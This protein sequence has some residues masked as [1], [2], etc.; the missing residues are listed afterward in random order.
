MPATASDELTIIAGCGYLGKIIAGQLRKSGRAVLGIT[1][2]EAS[3]GALL[4]GGIDARRCDL[5]DPA[6]CRAMAAEREPLL[7]ARRIRVIHCAASGRGGGP[8]QYRAVYLEGSRNLRSAFP[9][10]PFFLTSSTSVYAQI[11]G[12]EVT[13]ASPA[14]PERETGRVLRQAEEETLAAGGTVGRLAGIYG[15]GRSVLLRHFLEGKSAIDIRT[16]EPA[17]PDGRWINQIHAAD[18]SA[19]ILHLLDGMDRSAGKEESALQG[20]FG[21]RRRLYNIADSTPLIQRVLYTELAARFHR[22][23]PPEA[24]PDASRKRGWTHKRVSN[25]RLLATGWKPLY[26]DWFTALDHDPGFLP[27][28][29][30][31]LEATI[32]SGSA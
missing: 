4:E 22:P 20:R 9:G 15:P 7:R 1:H 5:T 10:A 21:E 16:V 2:S 3:A 11:D 31:Q 32:P 24:P 29:L 14:E 25:G 23:L 18:A 12:S 17:T 30:K 28:I 19:A 27:S 26:P 6:D 8:E 13:E